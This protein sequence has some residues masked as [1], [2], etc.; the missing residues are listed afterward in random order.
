MSGVVLTG[1]KSKVGFQTPRGPVNLKTRCSMFKT[2]RVFG[3]SKLFD[4]LTECF[5]WFHDYVEIVF[6]MFNSVLTVCLCI[7]FQTLPGFTSRRLG[8][9]VPTSHVV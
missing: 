2:L 8:G 3:D 9:G 6:P 4:D 1:V 7:L 5:E